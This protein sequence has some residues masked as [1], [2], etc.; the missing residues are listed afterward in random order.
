MNC[1]PKDIGRGSQPITKQDVSLDNKKKKL[2]C[3]G[4]V[5]TSITKGC[6]EER[7]VLE[8]L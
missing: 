2:F 3:D 6:H 1:S 7:N 5:L 8:L 4:I